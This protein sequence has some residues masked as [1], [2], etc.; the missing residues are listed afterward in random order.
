MRLRPGI[1]LIEEQAG[2]SDPAK[3]GDKVS[4]RYKYYYNRGDPI[5][6]RKPQ[7]I[8]AYIHVDESGKTIK[9]GTVSLNIETYHEI[10]C[11][12]Y[13]LR[14]DLLPGMYYSILGMTSGGYR[15]VKV[16]PH[17]MFNEQGLSD[18][19]KPNSVIIAEIW[20]DDIQANQLTSH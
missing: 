3:N 20:L 5:L 1:K 17:F 12:S 8:A 6:F 10:S 18:I 4:C 11:T 16:A 13:L 2:S 7:S 9:N 14:R 15:K 19:I